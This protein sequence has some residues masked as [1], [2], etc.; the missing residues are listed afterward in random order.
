VVHGE[1]HKSVIKRSWKVSS[2]SSWGVSVAKWSIGYCFAKDGPW[3]KNGWEPLLQTDVFF[4]S[5]Q[6]SRP[7]FPGPPARGAYPPQG[8]APAY[9]PTAQPG[10]YAPSR[11][12]VPPKSA[13]KIMTS[14]VS[15]QHAMQFRTPMAS[16][17]LIFPLSRVGVDKNSTTHVWSL[18]I[19]FDVQLKLRSL[20]GLGLLPIGAQV[21]RQSDDDKNGSR[22]VAA[23]S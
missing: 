20:L 9:Q 11:P 8:G 22:R 10:M 23:L 17:L 2:G 4:C 3:A 5:A 1:Y 7:G 16:M 14:E 21:S 15:A 19:G 6:P 18:L 13:P 12:V